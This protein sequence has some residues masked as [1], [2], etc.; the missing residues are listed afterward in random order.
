MAMLL[1]M[2][3]CMYCRT[4]GW[5]IWRDGKLFYKA[6]AGLDMG[7]CRVLQYFEDLARKGGEWSAHFSTAEKVDVYKRTG[8]ETWGFVET[9]VK[10]TEDATA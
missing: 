3:R 2:Q 5:E 7:D 9:I 1:A 8:T 6:G 4:W 10:I